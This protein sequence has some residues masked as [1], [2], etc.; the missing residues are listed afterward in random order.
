MTM[1]DI[2]DDQYMVPKIARI[3]HSLPHYNITFHRINNTF[4]PT[5][6]VYL[7][8]SGIFHQFHAL[9]ANMDIIHANIYKNKQHQEHTSGKNGKKTKYSI[10]NAVCQTVRTL[11]LIVGQG[12]I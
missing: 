7:E 4:R 8:V 6:E 2:A 5:D 9:H 3:L 12:V 10:L 1:N 11:A